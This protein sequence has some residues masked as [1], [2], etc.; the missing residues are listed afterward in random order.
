M[1]TRRELVV[2]TSPRQLCKRKFMN[3]EVRRGAFKKKASH[4]Q[5]TESQGP[6]LRTPA[7]RET[8]PLH[9]HD[10]SNPACAPGQH[11]G[12]SQKG[13]AAAFSLRY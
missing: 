10:T 1:E 13:N 4:R 12:C 5:N 2:Y 9:G 11:R 8:Q 3:K 6:L 7:A